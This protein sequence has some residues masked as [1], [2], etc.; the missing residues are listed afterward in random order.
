MVTCVL[1]VE[2]Q[3]LHEY[4]LTHHLQQGH[5]LHLRD[6][7]GWLPFHEACNHGH[8][9]VVDYLLNH[10]AMRHIDATGDQ[11]VTPLI[12]AASAGNLQII[13][14]LLRR[15]ANVHIKDKQVG[16]FYSNRRYFE[17]GPSLAI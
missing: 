9:D 5:P 13:K 14:L 4:I 12:D 6:H 7:V 2:H 11:G 16:G 17:R 8:S 3:T 15:G 10:G 1:S